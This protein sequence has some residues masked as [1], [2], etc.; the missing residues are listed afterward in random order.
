MAN[1]NN[2]TPKKPPEPVKPPASAPRYVEDSVPPGDNQ[3]K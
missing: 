3:K 2:N 1:H